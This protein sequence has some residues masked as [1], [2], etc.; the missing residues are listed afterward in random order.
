MRIPGE[1]R[2][3]KECASAPMETCS[4][5]A[6]RQIRGKTDGLTVMAGTR[7][8]GQLRSLGRNGPQLKRSFAA[9]QN[10]NQPGPQQQAQA[11]GQGFDDRSDIRLS[12]QNMGDVGQD[13]GAA[14]LFP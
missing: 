13:F 9:Q 4:H 8:I 3:P 5:R 14:V 1:T 6:L 7:R 11:V 10:A 12:V 2:L